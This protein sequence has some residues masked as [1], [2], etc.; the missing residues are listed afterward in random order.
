MVKSS[1][2]IPCDVK[3]LDLHFTGCTAIV[4]G[5]LFSDVRRVQVNLAR[6]AAVLNQLSTLLLRKLEGALILELG[7]SD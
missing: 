1:G 3:R 4:I 5:V 2:F 6:R 7:K